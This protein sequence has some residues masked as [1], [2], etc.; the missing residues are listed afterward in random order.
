MF[1]KCTIV[2]AILATMIFSNVA[3]AQ[4]KTTNLDWKFEKARNEDSIIYYREISIQ[5]NENKLFEVTDFYSFN[6]SK[7]ASGFSKDKKG[8][9]KVGEWKY[10]H[11]NGSVYKHEKF[12]VE[13]N[14]IDSVKAFYPNGS[15][16]Y[17]GFYNKGKMSGNWIF[18]HPNGKVAA[19][20]VYNN[21]GE[22][23][24]MQYFNQFG[25]EFP[26]KFGDHY[27]PA[28]YGDGEQYLLRFLYS[29]MVFPEAARYLSESGRTTIKATIE[30]DGR[31]SKVEVEISSDPILDAEALRV[32]K[33]LTYLK[34]ALSHNRPVKSELLIPI[35]F[36]LVMS[37]IE[38]K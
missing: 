20:E 32:S 5:S 29:K 27:K 16:D 10:Y 38:T 9:T 8:L 14:Q 35:D 13:G 12:D 21:Q 1:K 2:F 19:I 28:Q 36:K 3:L 37:S 31:V 22:I 4:V 34:P 30:A 7:F 17:I 11:T 33:F 26:T 15:K 6:K 23:L 25:V 24:R 18:Y